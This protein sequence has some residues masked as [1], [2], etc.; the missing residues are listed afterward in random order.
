MLEIRNLNTFL[1]VAALQNF[2]KA[3]EELGYSQSNVSAQ[4]KQLE[5]EVGIALFDRIGRGVYL[6]SYGEAL[7]PYAQR[8]VSSAISLENFMKSDELLEGV[9]RFGMTNSLFE[10]LSET[11]LLNY[12]QRFPWVQVELMLDATA[13]LE[14]LLRH[15]KLDTAC[16]IGDPLPRTEW[17]IWKEIQVPIVLVSNREHPLAERKQIPL[18]QIV[19][20]ELILMEESAPYSRRFEETLSASGL[21]CRPFLRLQSADSARRLVE[22]G[23]FLSLLPLYSVQAGIQ[24]GTL[25]RLPV[26]EWRGTQYIQVVL[27]RGKAITPQITGFLEELNAILDGILNEQLLADG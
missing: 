27:H 8:V 10:L 13:S 21:T 19:E 11:V 9:I 12:H 7:V 15:G 16:L 24:A 6:T 25:C 1:R 2:T 20:Q 23:D 22:R 4:I 3:A 5:Q 18:S 17:R 14:N 26:P